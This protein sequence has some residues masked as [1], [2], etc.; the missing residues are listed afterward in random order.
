MCVCV[1]VCVCVCESVRVP[2][3]AGFAAA[4]AA[5]AAVTGSFLGSSSSLLSPKTA[6]TDAG[7]L[8]LFS[9]KFIIITYEIWLLP[10]P[11][12]PWLH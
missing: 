5:A 7:F 3:L 4:A 6:D 10:K 2:W 8:F 11:K 9:A 1:C 12:A